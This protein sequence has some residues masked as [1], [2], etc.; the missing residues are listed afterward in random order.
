[1]QSRQGRFIEAF[2]RI[3]IEGN[4]NAATLI[5]SDYVEDESGI[6]NTSFED[7]TTKITEALGCL[8]SI[9]GKDRLAQDAI[10][11]AHEHLK[12]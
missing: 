12:L 1:M 2:D 11:G 3:I 7:N 4:L 8:S 10:D 5:L 6:Y 9:L